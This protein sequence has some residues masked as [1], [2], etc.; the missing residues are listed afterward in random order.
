MKRVYVK[1]YLTA[2]GH[3][4][5][6]WK[7]VCITFDNEGLGLVERLL[8]GAGLEHKCVDATP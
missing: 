6:F 8:D 5:W 2:G 7:F 1:E 4:D 3:M